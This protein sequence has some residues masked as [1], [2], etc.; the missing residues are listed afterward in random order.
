[1]PIIPPPNEWKVPRGHFKPRRSA[2]ELAHRWHGTGRFP[3]EVAAALDAVPAL[4]GAEVVDARPEYPVRLPGGGHTTQIDLWVHAHSGAGNV[5][6]AVEG[7]VAE[8]FGPRVRTWLEPVARSR[9]GAPAG[10][11]AGKRQR[12]NHILDLLRLREEQVMDLHYQLLHRTASALLAPGPT[13]HAVM[14]VH[15]FGPPSNR[16][17]HHF[18]SFAA[19][20]GARAERGCI[21]PVPG[22]VAPSLHLGWVDGP[23]SPVSSTCQEEGDA[24]GIGG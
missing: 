5:S 22:R 7:K 6:I 20:L 3:D 12:L 17:F 10:P 11:S 8:P 23:F 2:Y 18:C 21:V 1:M 14:L 9:G 13:D 16:S 15:S 19:A 4:A 24:G